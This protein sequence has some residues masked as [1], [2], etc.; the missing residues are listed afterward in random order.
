ML[1]GFFLHVKLL[2]SDSSRMSDFVG[3]SSHASLAI[4]TARGNRVWLVC[5]SDLCQSDPTNPTSKR[6]TTRLYFHLPIY[7]L[8]EL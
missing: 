3:V 7:Q 1:L 5:H 6:S 2:L 8:I 4:C